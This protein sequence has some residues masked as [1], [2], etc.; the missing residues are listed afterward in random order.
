MMNRCN[1]PAWISALLLVIAFP[2]LIWAVLPPETEDLIPF[3]IVHSGNNRLRMEVCGCQQNMRG[4]LAP[5]AAMIEEERAGV[6]RFLLL[7]SGHLFDGREDIDRRIAQTYL[8]AMNLMGYDGMLI[9]EAEFSLGEDFLFQQLEQCGIPAVCTNL[10]VPECVQPPWKRVLHYDFP[11]LRIAVIGLI[12]M[13]SASLPEGYAVSDPIQAASE[14]VAEIGDAADLIVAL[15]TLSYADEVRLVSEVRRIALLLSGIMGRPYQRSYH[16]V[17][18]HSNEDGKSINVIEATCKPAMPDRPF[19]FLVRSREADPDIGIDP[20]I[21]NVLDNFYESLRQESLAKGKDLR[22]FTNQAVESLPG[23]A[24]VGSESCRGCHEPEY[25][26]WQQTQHVF[27]ML[28]LLNKNRHGLPECLA[29]HTTG[30]GY[31]GG[32]EQFEAKG[33]LSRVGCESCHGPGKLHSG[34]VEIG[35]LIRKEVPDTICLGCHDRDNDP[36][37][38]IHREKRRAAVTHRNFNIGANQISPR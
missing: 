14:A 18:A 4:G 31:P 7:D 20:V 10:Q 32:F 28:S 29:C 5:R 38:P 33:D 12:P 37:F 1:I 25:R 17:I 22:L 34:A 24:Y 35:G 19:A 26:H 16:S 21:R 13:D 2:P 27:S 30:Y 11:R 36:E 9:G 3:K 15:S 23:N 6:D 8:Q